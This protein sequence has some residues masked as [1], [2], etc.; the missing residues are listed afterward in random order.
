MLSDTQIDQYRTFGFL[1]LPGHLDDGE[2]AALSAELDRAHRDAFGARYDDRPDHGGIAGHY[3]PMMSRTRT[4]LSLGLVEDPRFLGAAG[5]LVGATVLPF[6]AEGIL[7]FGEAG[8]HDDAGPGVKA[9]KFVAY[10]EPLTAAGGALRLLAGSHHPEFSAIVRA[11][12]ARHPAMDAQQLRRQ[13]QELPLSVAETRPGDVIAFDWHIRHTSIGGR[14]R[15][16]WTVS[17]VRDPAGAE[18]A[19]RFRDVVV[20]GNLAFLAEDQDDY[21][22]AAYPPYDGHWLTPDP[23]QPERVRLSRRMR[24]LGM[25]EIVE[26]S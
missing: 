25:F 2:V 15:R 21:D 11:W 23:A 6:Y 3:L 17:Y 9:V 19:E 16:Q 20:D 12:D 10:L 26:R 1:V 13:V 22:H 8:F 4:P 5:Q 14:D 24:E 18:E 7:Y